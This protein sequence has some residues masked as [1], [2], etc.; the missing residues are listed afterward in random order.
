MD[1]FPEAFRRFEKVVDVRRIGSFRHLRL[2]FE[3]WAGDNWV[4]SPRQ[5]E[6]LRREGIKHRIP[7]SDY[8]LSYP[9]YYFPEREYHVP[10]FTWKYE[11]ITVRGKLQDRYRDLKTGRFI[12]KP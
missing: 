3:W 12:R 4:N 7:V 10:K 9:K 8:R 11:R 2:S 1:K 6:C 5:L